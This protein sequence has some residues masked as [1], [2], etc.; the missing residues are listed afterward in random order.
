MQTDKPG[1][2]RDKFGGFGAAPTDQLWDSI[3]ASL[4]QKEKKRRGAFWWW[5]GGLAAVLVLIFSVYQIGYHFG[6]QE[7]EAAESTAS[8]QLTEQNQSNQKTD[9][10][11]VSDTPSMPENT[12]AVEKE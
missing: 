2:L 8:N 3:A 6:K 10:L 12:D 4:D 7:M 9:E 1:S 5:F 11:V